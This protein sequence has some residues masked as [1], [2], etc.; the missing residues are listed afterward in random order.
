MRTESLSTDIPDNRWS[1]DS[2]S[3]NHPGILREDS[4]LTEFPLEYSVLSAGTM[5]I[6]SILRD[7]IF[8]SFYLYNCI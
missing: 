4:I 3:D 2:F 1:D 6:Y 5:K 7:L 8:V